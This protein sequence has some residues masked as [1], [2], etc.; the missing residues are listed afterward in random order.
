M[1]D[2]HSR[3]SS[4]TENLAPSGLGEM[5]SM[6]TGPAREKHTDRAVLGRGYE[7]SATRTNIIPV[8]S[9]GVGIPRWQI[10]AARRR[11]VMGDVGHGSWIR[12]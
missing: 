5:D 4:R 3:H 6:R 2:L 10:Q 11:T 12:W 8:R 9:S 7:K 1:V